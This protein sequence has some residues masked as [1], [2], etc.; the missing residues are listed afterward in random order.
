LNH[1]FKDYLRKKDI[2]RRYQ[3]KKARLKKKKKNSS[4]VVA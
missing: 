2:Q 1:K 4:N 3:L